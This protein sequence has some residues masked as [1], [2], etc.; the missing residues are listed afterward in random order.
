MNHR[1][2]EGIFQSRLSYTCRPITCQILQ[3]LSGRRAAHHL[4][5]TSSCDDVPGVNEAVEVPRG[6]LDLLAHVIFAVEVENIGD[7]I[8]S[9]LVVLY[10]RVKAGQ[11]E[12]VGEVF[13]V[14]LA[15]VFVA[16]GG[17][18]LERTRL[19]EREA[20]NRSENCDKHK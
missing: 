3:A 19:L 10:F 14:D 11:V 20:G 12:A 17:D 7:E 16:A 9:V 15:E 18:E 2:L 8:E 4:R 6:F 13:F 1:A 5:Q